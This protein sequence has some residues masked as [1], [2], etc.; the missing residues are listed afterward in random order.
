MR[1]GERVFVGVIRKHVDHGS[2][3]V[4]L[5]HILTIRGKHYDNW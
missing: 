3:C 4:I 2:S 1:D 5:I